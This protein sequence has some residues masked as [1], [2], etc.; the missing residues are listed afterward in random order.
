MTGVRF[1][2]CSGDQSESVG[3]WAARYQNMRYVIMLLNS[4]VMTHDG[5]MLHCAVLKSL[6]SACLIFRHVKGHWTEPFCMLALAN[7]S[8]CSSLHIVLCGC[9]DDWSCQ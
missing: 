2:S 4:A 7:A 3:S 8:C 1:S 9:V 6:V 5:Q